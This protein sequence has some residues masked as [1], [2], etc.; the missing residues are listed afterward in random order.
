MS[1]KRERRRTRKSNPDT[2][3]DPSAAQ[4]EVVVLG[5]S[6][7]TPSTV[8]DDERLRDEVKRP[9]TLAFLLAPPCFSHRARTRADLGRL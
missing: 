3:A 2:A 9:L 4:P 1:E 5:A 8:A 6:N 7:D